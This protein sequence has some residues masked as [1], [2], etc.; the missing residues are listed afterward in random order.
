MLLVAWRVLHQSGTGLPS[1]VLQQMGAQVAKHT[2]SVTLPDVKIPNI[3]EMLPQ[4]RTFY[5]WKDNDG[6]IGYSHDLP[7][8][9]TEFKA[10]VLDNDENIL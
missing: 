7:D 8:N 9:V 5:R 10:I 2:P 3:G 6:N 1:K 4:T